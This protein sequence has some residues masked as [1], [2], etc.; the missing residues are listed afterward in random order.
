[1]IK[2]SWPFQ[3]NICCVWG[4]SLGDWAN[5]EDFKKA[6]RREGG[7][8]RRFTHTNTRTHAWTHSCMHACANTATKSK[9]RTAWTA[10]KTST[11]GNTQSEQ[12]P[13]THK[14]TVHQTAPH[15]DNSSML[16]FALN[17]QIIQNNRCIFYVW[18]RIFCYYL[19]LILGNEFRQKYM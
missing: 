4:S 6:I 1:M 16:Y 9:Y 15:L 2:H 18:H 19:G 5:Q 12:R 8:S 13:G 10:A 11:L 7:G 14:G 17:F 3:W